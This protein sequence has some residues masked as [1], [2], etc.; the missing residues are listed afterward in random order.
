MTIT[1]AQTSV[2]LK[3]LG[4]SKSAISWFT[5]RR[6]II[7]GV[8]FGLF[9][10]TESYAQGRGII[11]AFPNQTQRALIVHGLANNAALSLFY[12]D[13]T[14]NIV[15]PSGYMVYRVMPILAL[16][17]A[18]WAMSVTTKMLRGQE[19]N[20]RWE[21]LLCGPFGSGQATLKSILGI[22]STLLGSFLVFALTLALITSKGAFSLTLGG[23]LYYALSIIFAAFIGLAIGAI[24]SQLAATRRS[25]MLYAA[26]AIIVLFTLRSVANTINGLAW[27]KNLTPFGWIDKLRPFYYAQPIWLLPLGL[28]GLICIT[29]A[30]FLSARRD[31]GQS[32]ILDKNSAKPRF[33]LLGSQLGFDFRLLRN[34]LFGWLFGGVAFA[35][36]IASIDKTVA[37]TLTGSGGGKGRLIKTFSNLTGNPDSKIEIAYLSAAGFFIITLLLIMAANYLSSL[38]DEET[39]GR[40]DNLISGTLS[41]GYWLYARLALV[42]GAALSITFIA[43]VVIWALAS[44]QGISVSFS[45]LVFGGLNILG[46]LLL[47]LGAGVLIYGLVPRFLSIAMYAIIAWSFTIDII[48][49]ALKLSAGFTNTSLLHYVSLVPAANPDW[50]TFTL[51]SL[52]GLA[53]ILLGAIAFDRRDLQSE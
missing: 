52:I 31:L 19:E 3:K 24:T 25:A 9:A 4:Y 2:N 23:S 36:L 53:G 27:L 14:A 34:V 29:G 5:F 45:S 51:I 15:S 48:S 49:S 1:D 46:P 28:F 30:V 10:T 35:T 26:V 37:K 39:S 11:A 20:G 33:S 44:A 43:N 6:S 42:L 50:R 38:R 21:L 12:G 22:G 16:V 8:L 7:G 13:K 32:L 18:I 41:R 17:A 40:L 47:L